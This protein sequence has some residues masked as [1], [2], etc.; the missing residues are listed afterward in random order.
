ME[1]FQKLI[2]LGIDI[3]SADMKSFRTNQ[4]DD[5]SGEWSAPIITSWD[6]RTIH[7]HFPTAKIEPYWST[8]RLLELVPKKIIINDDTYFMD[9]SNEVN[10]SNKTG[11]ATAVYYICYRNDQK[12]FV[13]MQNDSLQQVL[14]DFLIYILTLIKVSS[15]QQTQET[16]NVEPQPEHH[17][18][19][20]N[21]GNE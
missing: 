1:K 4:Y 2:E 7:L 8:D 17:D 14:I 9:L 21:S 15:Q 20:N 13:N 3:N 11:M 10:I 6:E 18:E 19:T 16:E 12:M 5:L